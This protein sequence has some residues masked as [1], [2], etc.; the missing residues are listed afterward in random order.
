MPYDAIMKKPAT[1]AVTYRRSPGPP[2]SIGGGPARVTAYFATREEIA[3]LRWA[4]KN[5]RTYRCAN[6]DHQPPRGIPSLLRDLLV[7]AAEQA[8]HPRRR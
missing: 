8:A 1:T 6:P 7:H 2:R 3:A 4:A 5:W